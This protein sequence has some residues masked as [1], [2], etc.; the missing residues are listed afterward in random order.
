MPDHLHEQVAIADLRAGDVVENRTDNSAATF[1]GSTPHPKY[2][3]FNLVIWRLT[4]GHGDYDGTLSFDALSPGMIV[5]RRRA[6]GQ[7]RG[8]EFLRAMGGP[9][10]LIRAGV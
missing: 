4:S 7:A 2:E 9:E 6:P 5:T 10:R 3:G 1:I 8:V